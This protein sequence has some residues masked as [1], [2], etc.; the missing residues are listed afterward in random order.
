MTGRFAIGGTSLLWDV[1]VFVVPVP[2]RFYAG[3]ADELDLALVAIR[4][5]AAVGL[6]AGSPIE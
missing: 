1:V 5:P 3:L 4:K 2:G 6:S